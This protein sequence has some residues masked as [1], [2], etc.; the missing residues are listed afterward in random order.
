MGKPLPL[1]QREESAR[2]QNESMRRFHHLPHR[3]KILQQSK[4]N[5]LVLSQQPWH[6][7][8]S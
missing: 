2:G 1:E 3:P 5:L 7:H 6:V 8:I 4:G